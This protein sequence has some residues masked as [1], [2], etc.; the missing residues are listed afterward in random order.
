MGERIRPDLSGG[1]AEVVPEGTYTMRVK[2]NPRYKTGKDSGTPYLTWVLAFT[3]DLEGNLPL[4]ENTM[5]AGAGSFRTIR[6]LKGLGFTGTQAKTLEAEKLT[7]PS[8][9]NVKAGVP[10]TLF[11]EGKEFDPKDMELQVVLEVAKDR[12]GNDR[13]QVK[14]YIAAEVAE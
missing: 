5:L 12:E 6:I 13:N 9:A 11:V 2:G 8:G 7:L 3:G 10:V 14:E 1:E 4:F